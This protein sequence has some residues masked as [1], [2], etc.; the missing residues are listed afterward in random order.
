MTLIIGLVVVGSV[1]LLAAGVLALCRASA[2]ADDR[3]DQMVRDALLRRLGDLDRPH[4]H[5]PAQV[6]R[7]RDKRGTDGR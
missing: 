2:A 5:A 7:L 4:P 3:A 1:L 6:Y